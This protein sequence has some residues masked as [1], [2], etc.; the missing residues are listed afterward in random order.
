MEYFPRQWVGRGT[1]F[2][3][4]VF[5]LQCGRIAGFASSDPGEALA[6]DHSD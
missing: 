6:D 3:E 5:G 1:G 2:E 4:I